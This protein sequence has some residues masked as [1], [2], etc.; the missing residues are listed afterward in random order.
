MAIAHT[1][2][3]TGRQASL[4]AARGQGARPMARPW[5]KRP[6]ECWPAAKAAQASGAHAAQM[7]IAVTGPARRGAAHFAE[8]PLFILLIAKPYL[9]YSFESCIFAVN[10]LC[11]SISW[12]SYPLL[13]FLLHRGAEEITAAPARRT[14]KR[15][16]HGAAAR[17]R[18]TNR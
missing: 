2:P 14:G 4:N 1:R 3:G 17:Q 15:L 9:H 7:R 13:P 16:G 6:G 12:I 10:T 5:P 8:N 11:I 18:R